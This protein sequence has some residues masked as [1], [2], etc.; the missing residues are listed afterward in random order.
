MGDNEIKYGKGSLNN[1]SFESSL[2]YNGKIFLPYLPNNETT[3]EL[4][5]QKDEEKLKELQTEL[6]QLLDKILEEVE[7]YT[8]IYDQELKKCNVVKKGFIYVGAFL[9]GLYEAGKGLYNTAKGVIDAAEYVI[10][11]MEKIKDSAFKSL[12]NFDKSHLEKSLQEL[13]NDADATID[14][15]Q[16]AFD[17]LS[18]IMENSEIRQM[19][20]DFSVEYVQKI[21]PLVKTNKAGSLSF[22]VLLALCTGGAGAAASIATKSRYF[23]KAAKIIEKIANLLKKIKIKKKFKIKT[24]KKVK[25]SI[26]ALPDNNFNNKKKKN[27]FNDKNKSNKP[28]VQG[29]Q[30]DDVKTKGCPISMISGEELLQ[31]TDFVLQGPLPLIFQRTYRSGRLDDYGL[32]YGWAFTL[33][34]CLHLYDDHLIFRDDE[35]RDIHCLLPEIGNSTIQTV[36]G[37]TIFRESDQTFKIK[38]DGMPDRIFSP[39]NGNSHL[40]LKKFVDQNNNSIELFYNE[41]GHLNSI[42]TSANKKVLVECD[43]DGHIC[44]LKYAD[45]KEFESSNIVNYEYDTNADLIKV[46]DAIGHFESYKYLNHLITQRTLKTGFNFYFEWDSNEK[47]ARCIRNYGDNNIYDYQF[48]WDTENQKSKSID[49]LGVIN[50]FNYNKFGLITKEKDGEGNSTYYEYDDTGK[51]IAITGPLGEKSTYTFDDQGRMV[52]SV[53]PNGHSQTF[54]YN[55]EGLPIEWI[56][57]SGAIWERKYNTKNQLIEATDPLG[58][59]TRFENNDQGLPIKI[60]DPSDHVILFEWDKEGKLVSKTNALGNKTIYNYDNFGNIIKI[61]APDESTSEL[62]YD[63]N[64]NVTK[65]VNNAGEE[66]EFIYNEAGDLVRYIDTAGRVTIYDYDGLS[67]VKRRIDPDGSVLEYEYDTERNLT[68]LINQNGERYQFKY[69]NNERLIEEIGFDGRIQRYQ[70]DASGNLTGYFDGIHFIEYIRDKLGNLLETRFNNETI[71]EYSYDESG[72]LVEAKNADSHVLFVY[73]KAGHL[74]EEHQNEDIIKHNYNPSGLR[75]YTILP[76]DQKLEYSYDSNGELSKILLNGKNLTNIKRD[77][78]GR[79]VN[80]QQGSLTTQ[81]EYDPVGRLQ[82]QNIIKIQNDS[83]LSRQYDYDKAGNLSSIEDSVK[84]KT[85]FQY[86]ALDRLKSVQGVENE[87]FSFDPAGN[88]FNAEQ[89]PRCGYVVGNRLKIMGDRCYHYDEAGNLIKETRGKDGETLIE[90][91]YNPL[92]QLVKVIK[93]KQIFEYV[94]DALGRRIVKKDN[95]EETFFLWNGNVLL[96]ESKIDFHKIYIFEP[97]TFLP[98][99]F[100]QDENIYYYHLDHLGT[101][102]EITNEQGSVVWSARYRAYGSIIKFEVEEVE[103]N[104]RFQGQYFDIETGLHYNRF[105]Y[106]DPILGRF[107]NHDPIG[108]NGG[109]NFYE[110]TVNPTGWVDP[111]G[112]CKEA[113]KRLT[114]LQST[115]DDLAEKYLLP[116]YRKLDPNLKAGYTGSFKEGVVGNPNKANFGKP[117][118]LDN[119]DI[120]Y[121]IE[122][123]VLYKKF[124]NSLKADVEFRKILSETPGFEGLR[125][126]KKGFSIKFK[127]SS[128]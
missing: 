64:G 120:D 108:L 121:W 2:N 88:I 89:I 72:R 74:I 54:K 14:S 77:V 23:T 8:K 13:A 99:A 34:E 59:I 103:N 92:N 111:F 71:N 83:L 38:K 79:P 63:A 123:D 33:S 39:V 52:E 50:E 29:A 41:Q 51:L 124:G 128:N 91:F 118:N 100:V 66:K 22:D 35:G 27:S 76:D 107:I 10:T 65:V 42:N 114:K 53:N 16:R 36:E 119:F 37:L 44:S 61:V 93:G 18:I 112:L 20:L 55:S 4:G 28:S 7:Q 19:L 102:Q 109:V 12:I 6:K 95:S 32:G 11:R 116:K 70:Y 21:H 17:T 125:P 68:A 86:D 24:N 31:Q 82:S 127:P 3:V 97:E 57:P 58:N 90:Y 96:S 101:P 80:F 110:Y 9:D 67:Q 78:L 30:S 56:D 46:K 25:K 45:L 73:D 62:Q 85:Y 47:G 69:D 126:N 106:Y 43:H 5:D 113:S 26:K 49:S 122:S 60:Q 94:Y 105:R 84:G 40:P 75:K 115:F 104:L 87:I 15:M 48:E 1:P 98:V 117:V 81:F